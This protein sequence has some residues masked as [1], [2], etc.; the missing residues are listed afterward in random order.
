M[1]SSR[2]VSPSAWLAESSAPS[3]LPSPR[4]VMGEHLLGEFEV[5]QGAAR[6]QVV[7]QN[8]LAVARGP[9]GP[10]VAWDDGVEDL[11]AEVAVTLRLHLPGQARPP[12]EHRQDDAFHLQP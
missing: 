10:G 11:A 6:A 9:R 4:L 8:G 2:R 7:E 3:P 12:V 5:R 1:T